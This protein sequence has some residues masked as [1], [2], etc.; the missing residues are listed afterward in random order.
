MDPLEALGDHRAHPEQQRAF[1]RPVARGARSIFLAG[2]HDQGHALGSVANGGVEDR[3]LGAIRQVTRPVALALDELVAEADV[4]ERA[5]HHHLVVAAPRAEA[6]EL[7]AL[8]A[9]LDEVATGGAVL[10]YRPR[11]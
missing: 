5:A 4:A 2:D 1:S 9:V 3:H 8:D 7:A 6:V 10:R 11:G